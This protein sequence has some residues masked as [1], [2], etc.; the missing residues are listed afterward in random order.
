MSSLDHGVGSPYAAPQSPDRLASPSAEEGP[1]LC[2]VIS[3]EEE[4]DWSQS[5]DP[6]ATKVEAAQYIG[7]AQDMFDAS[8]VRPV[9]V[10]DYPIA[11]SE[12]AY[13]HFREIQDSGRCEI[14]A[15]LHPWVTPPVEEE[16]GL[17]NSFPGNLPRELEHAK[18]ESLFSTIE[19]NFGQRPSSYQAGRY[20]FGPRTAGLLREG[21]IDVDFSASAA[22]DFSFEGGPDYSQLTS[23][24][25]W[26]GP[27]GKLLCVPVSG[28]YLGKLG[29]LSPQAHRLSSALAWA[30]VPGVLSRM[31]VLERLRLSPEG[32]DLP[33][34]RRL[35][36]Y[37]FNRGVRIFAFSFHSPSVLPGCT[38]YVRDARELEA[39][40]DKCRAYYSF[41]FGELGG[42]SMTGRELHSHLSQQGAHKT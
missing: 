30:R 33:D 31:G 4:F 21:G 25:V 10:V 12:D 5:F 16:I 17:P 39:F 14:G 42:R 1:I 32:Y 37:L 27:D 19:R 36:Q 2:T 8:G 11:S 13:P 28:A 40:L 6:R 18:L 9:Y 20:G 7:R 35:T 29:S 26:G 23:E 22:F 38:P 41:F 34:L 24:S 3:T 15:H